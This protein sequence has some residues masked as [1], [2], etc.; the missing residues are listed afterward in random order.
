MEFYAKWQYGYSHET[1]KRTSLFFFFF[2]F[3]NTYRY[4]KAY[5]FSTFV[6]LH[7]CHRV[8]IQH[9]YILYIYN[10]Y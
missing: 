1:A 6:M 9:I 8:K 4:K 7:V 3:F 2:D 10:I 5:T